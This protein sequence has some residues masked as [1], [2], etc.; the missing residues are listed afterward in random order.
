MHILKFNRR[1][2]LPQ[3]VVQLSLL[4][5]V[6]A[7]TRLSL[8]SA[9]KEFLIR[10]KSSLASKHKAPEVAAGLASVIVLRRYDE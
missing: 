8:S 1:T 3:Q 6:F 9:T 7:I 10:A 5:L 4:L 2:R